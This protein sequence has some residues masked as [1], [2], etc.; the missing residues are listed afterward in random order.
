MR[1][2]V[3][4]RKKLSDGKIMVTR[5]TLSESLFINSIKLIFFVTILWPLEIAFW[6]LVIVCK[7]L[8]IIVKYIFKIMLWLIKMPFCLLFSKRLPNF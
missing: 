7:I 5:Y 1:T 8:F 3:Y 6:L 2:Y 4:D